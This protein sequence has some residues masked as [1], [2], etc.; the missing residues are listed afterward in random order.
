MSSSDETVARFMD[1]GLDSKAGT[2]KGLQ[3][4]AVALSRLLGETTMLPKAG[5]E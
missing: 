5:I 1:W 3:R 2:S 4:R